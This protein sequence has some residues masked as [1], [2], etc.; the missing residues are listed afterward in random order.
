MK[1]SSQ[2]HS[3]WVMSWKHQVE[4]TSSYSVAGEKPSLT[5]SVTRYCAST[6]KQRNSGWRASMLPSS[7]AWR[8]AAASTSSSAWV[9]RN[10][11]R[12]VASGRWPLR[13][14]RCMKRATPFGPPT[15]TTVSTGR[16]S[17]PRSRLLVHTTAFNRP[18]SNAFSTHSRISRSRL[19][20][21]RAMVPASSGAMSSRWWYQISL[22]ARVLVKI[23]VLVLC[24]M[25]GSNRWASFRPRCP[26][27]G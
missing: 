22:C 14:A 1:V 7:A 23:S 13:P 12:L 16:K 9:G 26:A 6:S 4:R 2:S 24:S 21:C 18:S 11:M 5:A 3:S 19:P 27:Q 10:Q 20:W 8:S 25:T 17:T 15:C